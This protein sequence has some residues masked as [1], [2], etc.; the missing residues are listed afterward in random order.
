M[1]RDELPLVEKRY[2]GASLVIIL[3]CAMLIIRLWFIQ[4]YRGDYYGKIAENNRIR[5]IEVSAP[6]GTIFDRHG[7][8]ILG[9]RPFYDLVYIPQYVIDREKTIQ[10]ISHLMHIPAQDL[11][12]ILHHHRGQPK[13]LP[14]T[15]KRNL[16]AHEVSLV[17]AYKQFLPGIDINVAPRRDYPPRAPSHLVGY[18]AEVSA[19]ELHRSRR[20]NPTNPY[21]PGELRGKHGL[22]AR[23]ERYLRG[24]SGHRLIQVDA[25]GRRAHI[26]TGQGWELPA[27]PAIPGAN[28]TLTID[29]KLQGIASRAFQG[30]NG[31]V[32]ALNPQTG[33]ILVMLSEPTFDPS[34]YQAG[35]SHEQWSALINDPFKPLFDKATGGAFMPGSV[36]KPVIALAALQEG[37]ITEK[38]KFHC[39]GR[40]EFGRDVFH[41]WHRAGHGKVN[42]VEAMMHSCDIFFYHV[43]LE[44]GI[45]RIARYAR[46]FGLGQK[47]GIQ[48][49]RE[50]PGLIPDSKY[51]SGGRRLKLGDIP[52]LAIGQGANLLTPVQIANLYASFANGGKVL[53]PY[54][55]KTIKDH[56]GETLLSK[57]TKVIREVEEI[58]PKYFDLVTK[59][60]SAVVNHPK[61][62]GRRAKVD[63]PKVAGKTA[64]VQVVSLKKNRNRQS[65]VSRKWQEHAMFAAFSPPQNAEIVV[66]VI[67]EHDTEGGGGKAAAPIAGK[68]IQAY[69]DLKAERSRLATKP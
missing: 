10:V 48:L 16:S 42:L 24:K 3:I 13:F 33:E 31:A 51:R 49:N 55:V 35:I 68:I 62:T 44:L 64:S 47:L 29:K 36:Y 53:S 58:E 5:R 60:L 63:G 40:F 57:E 59:A 12:H 39:P 15:L 34:I 61:G 4:V 22:E 6:R 38:T 45:D 50:D 37:V 2:F 28:L 26:L 8:M 32:V 9:N 23:W 41:C 1:S 18:L 56:L 54:L 46:A 69:W 27:Q 25:F 7:E 20:E 21:L 65:I 19:E 30:K 67:S 17:E 66:A 11:L 43:G 14:L 52:P